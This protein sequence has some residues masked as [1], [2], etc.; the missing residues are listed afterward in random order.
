MRG[1]GGLRILRPDGR[2]QAREGP[3]GEPLEIQAEWREGA[4]VVE[5]KSERGMTTTE[6][7]A[8]AQGGQALVVSLRLE[9]GPFGEPLIFRTHYD[10]EGA[11]TEPKRTSKVRPS[12]HPDEGST[13]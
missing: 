13:P 12:R 1:Q 8:L 9:G 11:E 5:S 3:G 2:K 4:L 6:T 10:L 7:Y